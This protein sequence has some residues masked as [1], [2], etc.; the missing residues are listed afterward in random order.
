MHTAWA[1][2]LMHANNTVMTLDSPYAQR[3]HITLMIYRR[4]GG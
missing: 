2:V 4:D 3:S 1:Q